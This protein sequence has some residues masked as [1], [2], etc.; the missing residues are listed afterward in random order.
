MR[1]TL[2]SVLFTIALV[3][4]RDSVTDPSSASRPQ[5][6]LVADLA[7][8]DI[9]SGARS[10]ATGVNAFGTIV[11]RASE[12]SDQWDFLWRDGHAA[13][14]V[15]QGTISFPFLVVSGRCPVP[16]RTP[17]LI[18]DLGDVVGVR[19]SGSGAPIPYFF[20]DGTLHDLGAAGAVPTAVN[21]LGQAVGYRPDAGTLTQQALLWD[22]VSEQDVGSLGGSVTFA[23]DLNDAGQIVG[24]GRTVAGA[25]RAFLW[26][27]GETHELA[28]L[29]GGEA[30]AVSLNDVGQ[31]AGC[32]TTSDGDPH[33]VLWSNGSIT[34]LGTLGG[35]WSYSVGI[36]NL[37][38]VVGDASTTT[39]EG[40]AFY[41]AE[42]VMHDLGTLGGD[43]SAAVDIN[44]LDQV[45][46]WTGVLTSKAFDERT[47]VWRT[48][49]RDE[50][51][52]LGSG[53]RPFAMNGA[54]LI[55]GSAATSAA[56]DAVFWTTMRSARPSEEV[57][58]LRDELAQLISTG[59]LGEGQARSL[60]SKLDVVDNLLTRGNT[61]G[62]AA[63]FQAFV[64]QLEA[65]E[66]SGAMAPE[67]AARLVSA[68]Q[69]AITQLEGRT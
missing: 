50:L 6:S 51:P 2:G 41:W 49:V 58:I 3:G 53:T 56:F 7:I 36:N 17:V 13:R 28:T 27:A 25:R 22:R 19:P 24:E 8:H 26:E 39:G 35:P 67:V 47:F 5:L 63:V 59:S 1:P 34:D 68:A 15:T 65:M 32:G 52:S 10:F 12:G 62:A 66:R 30:S 61:T 37:G 31:A 21:N 64:R 33:A 20:R 46:A 44:D 16:E 55:A 57:Q 60:T 54:G 69:N 45:V 18:N 4:C 14:I 38:H 42:G 43:W 9:G 11:G 29:G 40:H 48:G 23:W